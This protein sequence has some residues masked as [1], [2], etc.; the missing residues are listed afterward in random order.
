MTPPTDKPLLSV[1]SGGN[2]DKVP[3][4]LMR[5]AGRYLPEYRALRASQGRLPRARLRSRRRGR[6]HAAADPPL[7][8]RR[9]DPVLRHPDRAARARPG[10]ALRCRRWAAAFAG[11]G[12]GLAGRAGARAGPARADLPHCGES[13]GGAPARNDFARLRRQPVDGRDLHGRGP[14]QPRPGRGAAASLMPIPA[15]SRRSS[16]RSRR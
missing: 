7:R 3:I 15:L 1:L 5:Q 14:G 16:R 9:G 2:P 10:S 11:P 6:D 13:E 8:L 12:R 4:W